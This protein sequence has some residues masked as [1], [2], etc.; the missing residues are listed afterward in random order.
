MT[1]NVFKWLQMA[2]ICS[3]WLKMA[4]TGSKYLQKDQNDLK[5]LEILKMSPN[6]PK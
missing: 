1:P 5:L 6:G 2:L 4:L 3:K